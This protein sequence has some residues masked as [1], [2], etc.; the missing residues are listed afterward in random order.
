VKKRKKAITAFKSVIG[1]GLPIEMLY[2][3]YY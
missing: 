3:T 2:A 1:R